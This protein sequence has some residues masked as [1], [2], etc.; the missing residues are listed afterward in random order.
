MLKHQAG[1]PT[2]NLNQWS[3]SF[4][5]LGTGFKEDN[6]SMDQGGS[7][8]GWFRGDS[9]ALR[10]LCT[11]ISVITSAPLTPSGIRSRQ[12]GFERE[13]EVTQS[14][15]TLCDPMDCSLPDFSVHGIFQARV[16]EWVAISFSR[17]SSRPR[18][19]TQVSRIAGRCFTSEPP[20]V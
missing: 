16:L 7:K 8:W 1:L 20:G 9:S 3:P 5:A 10:L 2:M 11:V 19:R 4:L 13:S 14:C 12:L 18:D 17:G 6:F 15:P